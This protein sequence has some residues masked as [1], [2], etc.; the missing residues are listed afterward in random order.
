MASFDSI[1]SVD[2]D[3]QGTFKYVLIKLYEKGVKNEDG[4]EKF[5]YL[6]RGNARGEF[7]ADIYD[8]FVASLTNKNLDTECI[9]GGRIKHY[10]EEKKILVYGYSQGFGKADH[11]ITKEI[12]SKKYSN[13]SIDWSDEGY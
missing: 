13:Y 2:I 11:A 9:G 1:P 4:S 10:P 6:V 3:S 7:H 5:K 8:A 12:L